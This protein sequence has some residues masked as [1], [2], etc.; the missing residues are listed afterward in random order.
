[1]NNSSKNTPVLE[2]RL[3][4]RIMARLPL[5]RQGKKYRLGR[6]HTNDAIIPSEQ[7]SRHHFSIQRDWNESIIIRDL[8]STNGIAIN[9]NRISGPM[10]ITSTD[11]I[12]IGQ[13]TLHVVGMSSPNTEM[14]DTRESQE[15]GSKMNS[16]SPKTF[17][18]LGGF[19]LI[20]ASILFFY[21][22]SSD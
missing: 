13:L 6:D 5:L 18:L 12:R 4:D 21:F 10:E 14:S 22:I 11:D 8:N 15:S 17:L 3:E 16:S 9:G 19:C 20:I 1:M 2:I 7:I